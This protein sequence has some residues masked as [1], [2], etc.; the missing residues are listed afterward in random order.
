MTADTAAADTEAPAP[1]APRTRRRRASALPVVV[2]LAAAAVLLALT[3]RL[4]DDPAVRNQ[5]LAD[6]EATSHVAGEVGGALTEVFSYGPGDTARARASARRLL[7][8]QAARQYEEL[9]GQVERP[10]AD[11]RLTLTTHVVRTGVV[12]LTADRAELLVFL[13]QV[14]ERAGKP[15]ATAAAQLAVT[16][17]KSGGRWRITTL[18]AR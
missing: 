13:D 2:L 4:S 14:A 18:Q 6:P 1:P 11:Q 10:A 8:G 15:P 5:A 16:A 17:E 7:A 9:I 12:R 3:V